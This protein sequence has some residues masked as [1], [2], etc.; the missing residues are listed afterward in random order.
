MSRSAIDAVATAHAKASACIMNACQTIGVVS[1][2]ETIAGARSVGQSWYDAPH[3][4]ERCSWTA[5]LE[6]W[7]VACSSAA[8]GAPRENGHASATN[9]SAALQPYK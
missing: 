9:A 3:A 5:A 1:S 4:S 6:R 7:N 2:I 8:V